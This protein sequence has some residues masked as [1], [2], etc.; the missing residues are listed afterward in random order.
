MN[1]A[2]LKRLDACGRISIPKNIREALNIEKGELLAIMM[3]EDHIQLRKATRPNVCV[4]CK[5]EAEHTY[6]DVCVCMDCV[7]EM[8]ATI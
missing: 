2:I 8:Y 1:R 4:F 5:Q 6:K 7:D 3:H